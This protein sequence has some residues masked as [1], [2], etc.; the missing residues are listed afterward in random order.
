MPVARVVHTISGYPDQ[1]VM[2]V[3]VD[4]EPVVTLVS[5][6]MTVSGSPGVWTVGETDRPGRQPI[7]QASAPG[8][9]SATFEHNVSSLNPYTS[10]EPLLHPLRGVAERGKRVQFFNGGWLV[11]GTWWWVQSLNIVETEKARNNQTS[12]ATL[13]WTLTEANRV[14]AVALTKNGIKPGGVSGNQSPDPKKPHLPG[15]NG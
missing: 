11:G 3:K 14:S 2:G 5:S 6:P 8:L 13:T 10:V 4:G 12:R 9:R 15:W 1:N 7:T